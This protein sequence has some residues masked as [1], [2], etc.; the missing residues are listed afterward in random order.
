[1]QI[2]YKNGAIDLF[3]LLKARGS[4]AVPATPLG[5][6]QPWRPRETVQYI[7]LDEKL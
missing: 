3:T 4:L 1:M 7:R 6:V 5:K 2:P